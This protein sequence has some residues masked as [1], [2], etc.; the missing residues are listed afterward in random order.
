VQ[1]R[2][3]NTVS[4]LS[5]LKFWILLC[6]NLNPI[7]YLHTTD[8]LVSYQFVWLSFLFFFFGGTGIWAKG[9]ALS[10]Q[11]LY[12]S[13]HISGPF[14]SLLNLE[15]GFRELCLPTLA[16]NHNPPDLSLSSSLD[17]R[18]EPLVPSCMAVLDFV[19][20]FCIFKFIFST[21]IIVSDNF[22]LC[23]I[24]HF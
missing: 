15:M 24:V 9:F 14:F 2:P 20:I 12:G 11:A 3:T 23:Y 21:T 5:S 16:S 6:T 10:K 8:L 18:H 19:F 13:N 17:Y 7:I 1:L 4:N 22:Y